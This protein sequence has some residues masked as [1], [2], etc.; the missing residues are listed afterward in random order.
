MDPTDTGAVA[1]RRGESS[2]R[3][4]NLAER[5]VDLGTLR[6]SN[7]FDQRNPGRAPGQPQI[8]RP[9]RGNPVGR[10]RRP[11]LRT[12]DGDVRAKRLATVGTASSAVTCARTVAP[13]N[14]AGS[15][16]AVLWPPLTR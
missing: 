11:L 16:S 13:E 10:G 6:R 5:A 15:G 3:E 7:G 12:G 14:E 8:Q 4:G 9:K 1:P 2:I